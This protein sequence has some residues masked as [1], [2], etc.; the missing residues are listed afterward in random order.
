MAQVTDAGKA[1]TEEVV[2]RKRTVCAGLVRVIQWWRLHKL[3]AARCA[4]RPHEAAPG[5]E[6]Q[7]GE[8]R[9]GPYAELHHVHPVV[10]RHDGPYPHHAGLVGQRQTDLKRSAVGDLD[11]LFD[12]FSRRDIGGLQ[13]GVDGV[14]MDE[15]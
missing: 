8:C 12:L 2:T 4:L 9:R 10:V 7:V 6:I 5:V 3:P 11:E 15:L 14:S 13:W 1:S